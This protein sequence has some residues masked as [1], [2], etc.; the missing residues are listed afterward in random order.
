M[1]DMIRVFKVGLLLT[2]TTH[3]KDG[4]ENHDEQ[5]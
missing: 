4:I 1:I 2:L 3:L 5:C